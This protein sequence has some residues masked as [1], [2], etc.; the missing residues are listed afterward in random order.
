MNTFNEPDENA[1]RF[2]LRLLVAVIFVLACCTLLAYRLYTLQVRSYDDYFQKA[3]EN[4]ISI[5]PIVPQRG[6]IID[7]NGVVLARNFIAYTLEITPSRLPNV[8][9]SIN[10]NVEKTI[11][12]LS[13]IIT[14]EPR[15]RKRFDDFRRDNRRLDSVPIRTRL[16]DEEVAR[17]MIHRYRFPGVE[18]EARLF[19]DYPNGRLASHLIGYISRINKDDVDEIEK[20]D[21]TS[22]YRGSEHIGKNGVEAIYEAD[23]HGITG[24]EHVEVRASGK[25]VRSLKIEPSM[26]GNDIEL[27]IDINL[28]K[29]AEAA[30]GERRGALV[31]IEP[32]TGAVLA[33]VSMPTFDPNLFV[34]GISRRDWNQLNN[35]IDKPLLNR[36]IYSAYPPGSTFKPF[37]AMAGLYAG[38]RRPEQQISDPGFF[39]YAGHTFMDDKKGGH[40]RVD[41]HKSIVVSCNTYYYVLANDLGIDGISGFIGQFGLGSLT[42]IDL[43][44]EA[45]GVLPSQAWKR[46]RFAKQGPQA[47]KWYGGETISVGIGQGY[48]A[49]TP[50]QMA[51]A[52]AAIA[53]NGVLM[54]PR[55]LKA[56]V[57]RQGQRQASPPDEVRKIDLKP[58]YLEVIQKALGDV[59]RGGTATRSF[60]GAQYRAAGKTGTAQV[61]SLKG[62]KYDKSDERKRDHSWFIAYAPLEEPKIALA[63]LVE[64]GGFGAVS[65]APIARQVIDAYL[66]QKH[67]DQPAPEDPDAEAEDGGEPARG[68]AHAVGETR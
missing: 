19:R 18:V 31:A 58:E 8:G 50:V 56:V 5:Q 46:K 38:K 45:E 16:S 21:E 61:Y 67:A 52:M 40:G 43:P 28:Q 20:R 12:E 6:N 14:I 60:T 68:G 22:N 29:V 23:L 53:N 35:S 47:Q 25:P 62:Q 64:N 66:L 13:R 63:V 1:G 65:A 24:K 36:A 44:G 42:G 39:S 41:M 11:N 15:D 37:M 54:R 10:Q 7:R 30:F 51:A 3:E 55:V 4:R 33:L 26:A 57:D 48:N 49:Y 9:K 2:Y 17:F 59:T 32:S 27:S 34:D